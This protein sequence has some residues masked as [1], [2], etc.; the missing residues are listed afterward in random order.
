MMQLVHDANVRRRAV[1]VLGNAAICVFLLTVLSIPIQ[2]FFADR[3]SLIV[4]KRAIL[5][6]LTAI[7]AQESNQHVS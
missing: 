5:A 1:F 6:R 4:E 3:D 7:A 2:A